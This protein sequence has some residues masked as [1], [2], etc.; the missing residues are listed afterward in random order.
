MNE[1]SIIGLDLAKNV[2]QVHGSGPDGRVA[3]RKKISRGRL[4]EFFAR[5]QSMHYAGTLWSMG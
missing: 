3:L 2:F 1:I 5:K 4:L